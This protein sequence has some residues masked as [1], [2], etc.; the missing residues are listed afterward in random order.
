MIT[1]SNKKNM[2]AQTIYTART[3]AYRSEDS[4]NLR[5]FVGKENVSPLNGIE[6][7]DIGKQKNCGLSGQ[8]EIV[9]RDIKKTI[10]NYFKFTEKTSRHTLCESQ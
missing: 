8:L 3:A 5:S 1:D 6:S 10:S 2:S 7:T 9:L 4:D